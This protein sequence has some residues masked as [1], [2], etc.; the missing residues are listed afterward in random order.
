MW[1]RIKFH[2]NVYIIGPIYIFLVILSKNNL[3]E[4]KGISSEELASSNFWVANKQTK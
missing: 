1:F 4:E 3:K 2:K